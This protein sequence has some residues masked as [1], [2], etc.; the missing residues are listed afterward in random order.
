[1]KKTG[2]LTRQRKNEEHKEDTN[3]RRNTHKE[4]QHVRTP[5]ATGPDGS[6]LRLRGLHLP[7]CRNFLLDPDAGV[8]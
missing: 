7:S 2:A 4:A 8:P 6:A 3:K 1:M 5:Y